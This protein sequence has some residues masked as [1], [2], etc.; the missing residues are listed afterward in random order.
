MSSAVEWKF[1]ILDI[2]AIVLAFFAIII[3][4]IIAVFAQRVH[5]KTQEISERTKDIHEHLTGKRNL[6]IETN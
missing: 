2:I 3:S 6:A 1:P 5:S 4:V